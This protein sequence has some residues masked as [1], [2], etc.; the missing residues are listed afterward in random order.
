MINSKTNS[1]RSFFSFFTAFASSVDPPSLET[2][3]RPLPNTTFKIPSPPLLRSSCRSLNLSLPI[4]H[5]YSDWRKEPSWR[6]P[7]LRFC[8]LGCYISSNRSSLPSFFNLLGADSYGDTGNLFTLGQFRKDR[9]LRCQ[10]RIS[11]E[12]RIGRRWS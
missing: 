2:Y 4:Y 11:M 1:Q 10:R 6:R 8:S 3:L 12:W 9:E 7:G 5:I